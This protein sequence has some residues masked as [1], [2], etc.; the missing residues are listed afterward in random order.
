MLKFLLNKATRIFDSIKKEG[1][2]GYLLRLYLLG[3]YRRLARLILSGFR[4]KNK[5]ATVE[6]IPL[7]L[8]DRSAGIAEE[9]SIYGV[10]EPLATLIYKCLLHPGDIIFDVGTNIGY[11]V[12]VASGWLSGQCV[13]HGFEADP[14]LSQI[15]EKNCKNFQ[16]K[17]CVKH[18]AISDEVGSVK[19]F[20][21]SV[22]NWGSLRKINVLNIVD[23]TTVDCK[24]IDVFCGETGIYPTVIRMDIEG[25]EILALRGAAKSLERVRLLFIEL[26]CAFLDNNEL[27]EIFDILASAGFARA[28]WF[29]RYYDWPW[30]LPEG[31]R[32]SLRQGRIEELKDDSLNRKFKVITAFV[33]RQ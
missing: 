17:C 18:L 2:K 4:V 1:W 8:P 25:G 24:T 6:G 30:S 21:S 14:E 29:D 12:A 32:S 28:I 16:A 10:H 31:A 23:E 27:G 11:Y 33:L 13:V 26:H 19:F 3:Q 9:L 7:T 5:K 22:S 20:V 15:A